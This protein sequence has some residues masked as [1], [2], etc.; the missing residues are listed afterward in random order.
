M[1]LEY[2]LKIY[3]ISIKATL[4]LEPLQSYSTHG[5]PCCQALKVCYNV[6][7]NSIGHMCQDENQKEARTLCR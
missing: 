5:T 3:S 7:T 4:S 2:S 6:S 1:M